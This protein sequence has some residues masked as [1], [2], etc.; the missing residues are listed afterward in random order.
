MAR[1]G[2]IGEGGDYLAAIRIAELLQGQV[3]RGVRRQRQVIHHR[4]VAQE[5]QAVVQAGDL[6]QLALRQVVHLAFGQGPVVQ[7]HFVDLAVEGMRRRYKLLGALAIEEDGRAAPVMKS[8]KGCALLAALI[9]YDKP[10]GREALADLLWESETTAQSLTRLRI[11]VSRVHKWAPELQ[12]GRKQLSFQATPD[13]SVDLVFL[14]QAL[15][16]EDVTQLNEGLQL[17]EGDLLDGFYLNDVPRFD[18]WLL[19]E[20]ENLRHRV[21]G[22]YH[23]LCTAYADQEAWSKG[24]DAAQRWLAL[25]E[26]DEEALRFLMQLLAASGQIGVA[27]RQYKLSREHMWEALGVK[28]EA[29]TV[30][31]A[32]RLSALQKEAGDGL[33]WDVIVGAQVAPPVPGKLSEPGQLPPLSIVP[34]Q[35]NIDFTGRR[36][37]LL[38]L[39]KLLLPR[40]DVHGHIPRVAAITGMGGVGKTQLAVEFCYRYGRFFPGGVFWL[41]FADAQNVAAAVTTVGGEQGMG[42]Y[43]EAEHLTLVDRVGQVRRAWQEAIPRLLIFDD[44][45]DEELLA[46]WLP[47]SGGSRVL[48]TCHRSHWSH[49]L[50]V[51]E[52]PLQVM[53]PP[54]SVAYL[55]QLAPELDR[56]EALEI[57]TELGHLPLALQLAGGFLQRYRQVS[58]GRYLSQLQEMGL[59]GHPSLQGRGVSHSPTGHELNVFHT[60]ALSFE[61][62]DPADEIDHFALQLLARAACFAPSESIPLR[63]L[64]AT[65]IS[66][67]LD[68]EAVLQVEDGLETAG[69]TGIL[70]REGPDTVVIH[71]LV[72]AYANE[73]SA[74]NEDAVTAV[75]NMLVKVLS[76]SLHQ[77]GHLGRLPIA[78]N[79]LYRVTNMALS[80]K[81]SI[82]VRLGTLLGHHLRDIAD[83]DGAREALEQALAVSSSN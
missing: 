60:F 66:D 23:R 1:P 11:L 39:A 34:Y 51:A 82:A 61:Q 19:L 33:A 17:Y 14:R 25:D 18:E 74:T 21:I 69:R 15:E 8:N 2:V 30:T 38:H 68:L 3:E 40:A 13:A 42:L 71:R 77:H 32:Q 10:L 55:R 47:V 75:G 76:T 27:L 7:A 56:D 26:F 65:I 37:A 73:I 49:D 57:A 50:P 83:Y 81:A 41:N 20:R 9:I 46:K 48:L 52:W 58:A 5:L 64:L 78:A 24:I 79:H 54:E 36:E 22:A 59:I 62:L 67:E 63:L 31:L 28:P 12:V 70:K 72:V 44:C 16:A 80:A 43:R 45:E 35:R 6:G 53:R 29:A 4:A